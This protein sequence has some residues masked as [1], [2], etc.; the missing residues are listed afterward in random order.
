[1]E[2]TFQSIGAF[3][4]NFLVCLND[5]NSSVSN[6]ETMLNLDHLI[7][8]LNT[9][10]KTS[11]EYNL[12]K[13][14]DSLGLVFGERTRNTLFRITQQ[15]LEEFQVLEDNLLLIR[16]QFD[17]INQDGVAISVETINATISID[18]FNNMITALK[19][20][21]VTTKQCSSVVSNF[22]VIATTLDKITNVVS[23]AQTAA[24]QMMT[25]SDLNLAVSIQASK[26][27]FSKK[28][29]ALQSDVEDAFSEFQANVAEMFYG[30]EEVFDYRV[31][32]EN[33]VIELN[34]YF[35][36]SSKDFQSFFTEIEKK[37]TKK[38]YGC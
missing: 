14:A 6:T 27:M 21:E 31:L 17:Q 2:Y 8:Q 4:N 26:K 20:I 11:V 32:A 37:S 15:F 9:F 33:F 24:I 23:S 28:T 30:D 10:V 13:A 36:E 35:D 5:Q 16:E 3:Y 19:D 1:M 12:G 7:Y 18:A 22:V 34:S 25:T 29:L 38:K